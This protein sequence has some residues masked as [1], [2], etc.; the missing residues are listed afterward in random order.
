MTDHRHEHLADACGKRDARTDLSRT[1]RDHER[2]QRVE[3]TI[4]INSSIRPSADV[5]NSVAERNER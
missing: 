3:R 1:A 5:V 2:Q 4:D